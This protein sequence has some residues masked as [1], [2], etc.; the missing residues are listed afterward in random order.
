MAGVIALAIKDGKMATKINL[1]NLSIHQLA[2]VSSQLR[3]I[4]N[5]ILNAIER[6]M[7]R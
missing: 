2:L 1:E 3:I 6:Q 5:K 7:K 4:D